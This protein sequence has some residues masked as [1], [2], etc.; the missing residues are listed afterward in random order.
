MWSTL[1]KSI[2]YW[3]LLTVAPA[4]AQRRLLQGCL[5]C[6]A[7]IWEP[8][9]LRASCTC[10][11]VMD[12]VCSQ[13]HYQE[14]MTRLRSCGLQACGSADS[15]QLCYRCG[16]KKCRCRHYSC[17]ASYLLPTVSNMLL[18]WYC[19]RECVRNLV[20]TCTCNKMQHVICSTSVSC[21]CVCFAA[22]W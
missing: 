22:P 2:D 15:Y 9:C 13:Q 6:S 7:V 1:R 20:S 3:L 11:R 14:I 17:K 5:W 21:G 8:C 19:L 18:M 4:G 16:A 12:L 10:W